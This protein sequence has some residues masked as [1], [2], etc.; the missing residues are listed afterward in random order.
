MPSE[1]LTSDVWN[2]DVLRVT[3]DS[4]PTQPVVILLPPHHRTRRVLTNIVQGYI[5]LGGSTFLTHHLP[6]LQH[7]L[8][9]LVGNVSPR[10][11]VYVNLIFKC[12][13]GAFPS[14]VVP[15]FIHGGISTTM[16]CSC[17]ANYHEENDYEPDQVIVIYLSVLARLVLHSPNILDTI[18]LTSC[19]LGMTFEH[20]H[21]VRNGGLSERRRIIKICHCSYSLIYFI[22]N[23]ITRVR[24]APPLKLSLYFRLF[25]SDGSSSS[26]R[27]NL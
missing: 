20:D 25:V 23:F 17:A 24:S 4:L 1:Y 11:A 2:F 7:I 15:L 8:S 16:I 26:V 14:Q 5:L 18:L 19:K 3:C 9:L 13:L 22:L 10:G 12:L 21:L 6:H 27:Q